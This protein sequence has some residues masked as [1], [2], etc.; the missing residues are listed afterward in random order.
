MLD[1]PEKKT[2]K[3]A[4]I[5]SWFIDLIRAV[6]LVV[7]LPVLVIGVLGGGG[8]HWIM[9]VFCVAAGVGAVWLSC[10]LHDLK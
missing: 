5:R 8:D 10:A 4:G 2:S 3:P 6:L 7:G 9:T 1:K